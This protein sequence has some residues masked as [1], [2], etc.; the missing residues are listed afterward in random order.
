VSQ[1]QFFT[2]NWIHIPA[3]L[4]HIFKPLNI[5]ECVNCF[6]TDFVWEQ[7]CK[8][9]HESPHHEHF[10][11]KKRTMLEKLLAG[12]ALPA[13]ALRYLQHESFREDMRLRK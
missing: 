2:I 7:S 12:E 9:C 4:Q 3:A 5:H 8:N 13:E 11:T 1:V 6:H 10:E